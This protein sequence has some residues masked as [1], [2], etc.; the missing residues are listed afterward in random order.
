VLLNHMGDTC[1]SFSRVSLFSV[2]IRDRTQ[3]LSQPGSQLCNLLCTSLQGPNFIFIHAGSVDGFS[4]NRTIVSPEKPASNVID[5]TF[6]RPT[7]TKSSI[8]LLRRIEKGFY[9]GR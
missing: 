9:Y 8:Y 7:M 5:G 1:P 6:R 2:K 4:S 3:I